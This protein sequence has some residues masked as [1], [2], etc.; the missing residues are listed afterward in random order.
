M[1]TRTAKVASKVGLHA[2]PAAIFAA[3]AE[4]SDYEITI[5]FDGEEAD[6]TS[7]LDV[8]SLGAMHGDEVT[9]SAEEDEA[10]ED[11]DR[12]VE[13]LGRDLES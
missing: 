13:L 10:A 1:I 5:S 11:L 2:R 12:L 3:A 8:M 6:A 7:I 4:E 9:L